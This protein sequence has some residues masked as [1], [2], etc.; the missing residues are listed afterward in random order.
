MTRYKAVLFSPD[1]DWV[2][3]CRG[4]TIEEV[5]ER[6]GDLGSR[7]Y[8]YPYTHFIIR[9]RGAMTTNTQ[10]IVAAHEPFDEFKGRT[11]HTVSK[12]LATQDDNFHA[13]VLGA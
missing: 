5:F 9:D 12:F 8:F 7:W 11:I 6:L 1:G 10:R 3:D 13:S 4:E 2:T